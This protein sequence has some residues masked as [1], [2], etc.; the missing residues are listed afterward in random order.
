MSKPRKY[1]AEIGLDAGGM[2]AM[3]DTHFM[4]SDAAEN[5]SRILVHDAGKGGNPTFS[6]RVGS[7][8]HLPDTADHRYYE[9]QQLDSNQK[10]KYFRNQRGT[11]PSIPLATMN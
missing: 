10:S 4:E 11:V 8:T 3:R 2:T 7:V 1:V 6:G 5:P 9:T